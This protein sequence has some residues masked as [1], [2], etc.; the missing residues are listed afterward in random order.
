L[1]PPIPLSLKDA[2]VYHSIQK[3]VNGNYTVTYEN[4]GWQNYFKLYPD[5]QE[6]ASSSI[7]VYS[8]IFSPQ[9]LNLNIVHQWQYHDTNENKWITDSVINLTVI[10]GRNGGFRTYSMRSNLAPGRWRV[11]IKTEQ[12]Q[13][14]GSLR[15]NILSVDK[16]PLLLSETKE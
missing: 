16:E 1:I 10:G 9:D 8:A 4:S 7:Y 6:T 13:I 11:N 14:I 12:G 5:F 2:G 15:F 3:N